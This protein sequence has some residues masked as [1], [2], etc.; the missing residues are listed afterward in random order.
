MSADIETLQRTVRRLR[1]ALEDA[2][3]YIAIHEPEGFARVVKMI[4]NELS[5]QEP[6]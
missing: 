3:D 2:R 1:R 4:D 6:G 5:Q